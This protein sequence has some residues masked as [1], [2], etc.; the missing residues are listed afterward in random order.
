MVELESDISGGSDDYES[1]SDIDQ[2]SDSALQEAFA[3]GILKPGLNI[4]VP[5]NDL[6]PPPINNVT[7]LKLKLAKISNDFPWEE[8]LDIT[9]K[10]AVLAPELELQ[11]REEEERAVKKKDKTALNEFR[12]ETLFHQQAQ[13]AVLEG[14]PK[15]NA[16]G[17]PTKRPGD[18]F[19]E[20]IKSDSQMERIRKSLIKKKLGMERAEFVK[21]MRTQKK[22]AKK[23]QTE[24]ILKKHRE[25]REF[26]NKVKQFKKGKLKDLDFLTE[27]SGQK[28]GRKG[29]KGRFKGPKL[30]KGKKGDKGS[31][32][33]GNKKQGKKKKN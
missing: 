33:S 13:A 25:K 22:I 5:A 20:M 17:I 19:A 26:L 9:T 2:D 14:I 18:S 3:K 21:K 27:G 6:P 10:P 7:A 4:Q 1:E 30:N 32:K 28:K 16:A 8:R 29:G 15:L 31:S 24:A 11:I 12:R 23:V